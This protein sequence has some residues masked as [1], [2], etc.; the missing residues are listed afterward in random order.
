MRR[1]GGPLAVAT[2]LLTLAAVGWWHRP[3]GTLPADVEDIKDNDASSMMMLHGT[4]ASSSM[5]P[6]DRASRQLSS[7][8]C[9]AC[10]LVPIDFYGVSITTNNFHGARPGP[11]ASR[12]IPVWGLWS[13]PRLLPLTF[14]AHA[15]DRGLT[16]VWR[17]TVRAW[18]GESQ[19]AA[20]GQARFATARQA[21]TMAATST[22]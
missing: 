1:V 21:S 20:P 17:A 18:L 8:S 4:S 12:R 2:T 11:E 19:A 9:A 14:A 13:V 5:L 10:D 22:S 3:E 15:Q 7:G 16:R 6:L